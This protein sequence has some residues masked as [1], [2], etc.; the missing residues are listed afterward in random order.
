MEEIEAEKS[1]IEDDAKG[2]M[3]KTIDTMRANF[4]SVRTGRANPSMLDKIEEWVCV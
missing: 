1:L 4:N 2:R 3:E